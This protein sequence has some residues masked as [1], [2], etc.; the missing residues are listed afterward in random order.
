MLPLTILLGGSRYHV[1]EPIASFF[2]FRIIF[3]GNIRN[4]YL[5]PVC[6]LYFI[7]ENFTFWFITIVSTITQTCIRLL[8]GSK[9]ILGD[10][11]VVAGTLFLAMSN[12]GEVG[13]S[14][15]TAHPLSIIHLKLK[16]GCILSI[17]NFLEMKQSSYSTFI[18]SCTIFGLLRVSYLLFPT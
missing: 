2:L 1:G 16:I 10:T 5:N 18:P 17:L 15:W 12:V 13:K 9:P 7:T 14:Q 6:S 8:G 4:N 3:M 11:L